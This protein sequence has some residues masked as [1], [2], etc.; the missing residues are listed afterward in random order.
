MDENENI[1][2]WG[3]KIKTK[4]FWFSIITVFVGWYVISAYWG[5]EEIGRFG[6]KHKYTTQYWV[7]LQSD[8]A[9]AKNYRVKADIKR[10]IPDYYLL[11][12]YWPNGGSSTFDDCLLD[13]NEYEIK[14]Y[15]HCFPNNGNS[16][17]ENGY[18]VRINT[19]D[20]VK[21]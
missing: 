3:I 4:Y 20:K 18:Y 6:E 7:D 1:N 2:F 16:V 8:S 9:E 21:Q 11:K 13:K 15:V 19:Y 17:E 10:E 14:G 12:V 5:Y